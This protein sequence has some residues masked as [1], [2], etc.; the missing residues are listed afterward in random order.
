[1]S[2]SLAF[3][4]IGSGSLLSCGLAAPEALTGAAL[5]RR[6][7]L[8]MGDARGFSIQILKSTMTEN[9]HPWA[10]GECLLYFPPGKGLRAR[11]RTGKRR[12]K[13]GKAGIFAARRE[14]DGWDC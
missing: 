8:N 10:A 6:L 14:A 5:L 9:G 1:M 3:G 12:R 13:Q 2:F 11:G 4:P 7:S